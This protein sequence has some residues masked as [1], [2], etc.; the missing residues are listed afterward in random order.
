MFGQIYEPS[1]DFRNED[2]EFLEE[3]KKHR[4]HKAV[5]IEK[6]LGTPDT[7]PRCET[8]EKRY[9]DFKLIYKYKKARDWRDYR[10]EYVCS[11]CLPER[12]D[13]L[14]E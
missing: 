4:K 8:C 1:D 9:S 10:L 12:L 13:E 11:I 6:P 7:R 5:M 3:V 2:F 14:L